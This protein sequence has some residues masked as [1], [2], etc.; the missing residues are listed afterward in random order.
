[1]A[2][3]KTLTGI[4]EAKAITKETEAM[5]EETEAAETTAAE[6]GKD[7]DTESSQFPETEQKKPDP[8]FE[9]VD[10]AAP[11]D[12]KDNA[13]LLLIVNGKGWQIKRGERVKIPR[14]VANAYYDSQ[15]Q[16][17]ARLNFE[18]NLKKNSYLGDFND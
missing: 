8:A 10:F 3:K 16:K 6:E 14:Y 2:T 11:I 13:D 4:E 5:T 15:Q 7:N 9:L 17:L 18:D 1:M 12:E